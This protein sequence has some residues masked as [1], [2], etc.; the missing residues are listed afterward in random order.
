MKQYLGASGLSKLVSILKGAFLQ[1]AEADGRYLKL[2]GG[3]LTGALS[4]PTPTATSH[5]A[6]KSY[7]DTKAG[8][9]LSA[10]FESLGNTLG[11]MLYAP[12]GSKYARVVFVRN[13]TASDISKDSVLLTLSGSYQITLDSGSLDISGTVVTLNAKTAK[14]VWFVEWLA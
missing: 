13:A 11:K 3:T 8:R 6:T 1:T 10:Q 7:V 9:V 12:T 2:T 14:S 4:I 5:A